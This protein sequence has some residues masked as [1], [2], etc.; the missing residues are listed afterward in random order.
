MEVLGEATNSGDTSLVSLL[1]EGIRR[2]LQTFSSS[3]VWGFYVDCLLWRKRLNNFSCNFLVLWPPYLPFGSGGEDISV[4][5]VAGRWIPLHGR[6]ILVGEILSWATQSRLVWDGVGETGQ[7]HDATG[8]GQAMQGDGIVC[9][10]WTEGGRVRKWGRRKR[11]REDIGDV[12]LWGVASDDPLDSSLTLLTFRDD[13]IEGL[14]T[15]ASKDLSFQVERE[16]KQSNI[17][18]CRSPA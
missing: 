17:C 1:R 3:P 12:R 18:E 8:K 6:L 14:V 11:R 16:T 5:S 9:S 13:W 15:E 10:P 7:G 4:L 2:N